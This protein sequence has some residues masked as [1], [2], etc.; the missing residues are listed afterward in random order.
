MIL[1]ELK[2]ETS[3][4]NPTNCYIILDETSKEIIVIDPAGDVDRIIEMIDILKRKC[5][6]H[7][8]NTLSRRPYRSIKRVKGTKRWKNFNTSL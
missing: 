2:I 4:E 1:K 7:I 5:K 3:I 6:I 8:F